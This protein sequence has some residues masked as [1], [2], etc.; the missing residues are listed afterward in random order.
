MKVNTCT[1]VAQLHTWTHVEKQ[2]NIKWIAHSKEVFNEAFLCFMGTT[3]GIAEKMQAAGYDW[4]E[5]LAFEQEQVRLGTADRLDEAVIRWALHWEELMLRYWPD[6]PHP[7]WPTFTERL[8]VLRTEKSLR[9]PAS[10][11]APGTHSLC[12]WLPSPQ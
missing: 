4:Q 11:S 1:Y 9:T 7:S 12:R 10:D 2:A 6:C 5:M 3:A 8:A